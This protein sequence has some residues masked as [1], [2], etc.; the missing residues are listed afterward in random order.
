MTKMAKI[1][2][3]YR[4]LDNITSADV[5]FEAGGETMDKLFENCAY[6]LENVMVNRLDRVKA[7]KERNITVE[8]RD[9]DQLLFSFLHEILMLKDVERLVFSRFKVSIKR[10]NENRYLL[11]CICKGSEIDPK[12]H[13]VVVDV[14]GISMHRLKVGRKEGAYKAMVVVDV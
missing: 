14:K 11:K 6:A 12:T 7:E 1:K 5:A 10:L 13:D 3:N 2:R 4:F 9:A 8:A